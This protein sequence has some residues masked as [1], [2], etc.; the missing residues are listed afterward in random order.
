MASQIGFGSQIPGGWSD[1]SITLPRPPNLQADDAALFS[2]VRIYGPGNRTMYAG[3]VVGVPQVGESEIR[4]SL[5][6]HSAHLDDDETFREIYVDADL[7]HWSNPPSLEREVMLANGT[8]GGVRFS[9]GQGGNS[10]VPGDPPAL[11]Q[12]FTRIENAG[13]RR[14]IAEAWYDSGGIPI[15]RVY[16]A[17]ASLDEGGAGPLPGG[18]GAWSVTIFMSSDDITTASDS[19]DALVFL[20][21]YFDATGVRRYVALQTQ[22]QNVFTGDGLWRVTWT[23]LRVYGTHGLTLRGPDPG[24][25]YA[26]DIVADVVGRAA[27]NL[28][29]R[30]GDTIE[31]S[32]FIVPHYVVT[33]PS[34]A[35]RVIEDLTGLGGASFAPNDWGCY[36][37]DGK[38]FFWR[39]P[40]TYGR[41][42]RVRRD[43]VA[44]TT[45]EG[46]DSKSRLGGLMVGWKDAA[47][48]QYT[49]GPVGSG[50]TYETATLEDTDPTNP[51]ARL[52]R[53]W[54][55]RD[56]GVL[57]G[58]KSEQQDLAV[59]LGAVLLNEANELDWRGSTTVYG[60][61]RDDAGVL[62]H[63][64]A[65]RAGDQVVVED[66]EALWT[67]RPVASTRYEHGDVAATLDIGASPHRGDTFLARLAAA[68]DLVT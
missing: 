67:P 33:E 18:A 29:F 27:P 23:Q 1:G 2:D 43:Q 17:A 58:D 3:R 11:L 55:F 68:A 9:T 41:T 35:R 63:P 5:E 60:E 51:A 53:R 45:A 44:V 15:A 22:Y 8:Y 64:A 62:H 25:L 32:T 37:E 13:A 38:E 47:G 19:H 57:G 50:A 10:V 36:G 48:R 21:T 31:T 66:N 20:N 12:E 56:V 59:R 61:A 34:T 16:Y 52:G 40:G 28:H 42:W 7:T 4:L 24:G 6:G 49:A 39:A 54:A 46:P 14:G 30:L 26:S 65:I